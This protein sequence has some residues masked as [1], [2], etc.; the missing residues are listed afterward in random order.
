MPFALQQ[1]S[2]FLLIM[3]IVASFS[4][5]SK[6]LGEGS[7]GGASFINFK[8][9]EF[10]YL[11]ITSIG[12]DLI[13]DGSECGFACLEI[14][15]CFSYNLAAFADISEKLLC[16]LLPSDK[17]NNSDKFIVSPLFHHYS[18]PSPCSSWPCQNN[19]TCISHYEKKSYVCHCVK[20]FTGRHCQTDINECESSPCVNNG[21]CTDLVNGFNCSC[22]VGFHGDRC[23]KDI[24]QCE[25]SPCLN[26]GTCINLDNGFNCSCLPGFSGD[27]C[28]KGPFS[29]LSAI[30]AGNTYYQ[31]CLH[32]FLTMPAV[33][34]HPQ[35]LL[36]YRASTH[37]WA[38]ST[39][40]GRC[41]GKRDTV[42][43]IK[44][45]QYV[46][47]GYTDIPWDSSSSYGSTSKAFIFSLRN[48]EGLAPFKRMV[49]ISSYA[50]YRYS[51]Y[52]PTFGHGWDIYIA[53]NAN[54]NNNSY[55]SFGSAYSVPSG[56]Q[57]SSTIL[58][59]TYN[60]SPDDWEVFYLG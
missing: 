46:F 5:F 52:G 50:I 11:N 35:W 51:G 31:K 23:E 59:G 48:K 6:G 58:A 17:Y 18:I 45:G 29:N 24:N 56:V 21:T 57:S 54:N 7:F 40:H 60:F 41:D 12:S 16:E 28:E 36:C 15:T 9:D 10:S 37:G 25:S 30:I 32:H 26:N 19:G 13:K 34:S 38:A 4:R 44:K 14:P 53:D 43:I 27:R 33:G 39:F 42:T 1:F 8:K 55:T 20:G 2:N 47:G 49:T 22:P 3:A